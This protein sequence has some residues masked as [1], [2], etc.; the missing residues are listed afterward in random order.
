MVSEIVNTTVSSVN[1]AFCK[2][3]SSLI[4]FGSA[5]SRIEK[6]SAVSPLIPASGPAVK[7]IELGLTG[8]ERAGSDTGSRHG[9]SRHQPNKA[10]AFVQG[11]DGNRR[12]PRHLTPSNGYR[13]QRRSIIYIAPRD[14]QTLSI[15]NSQVKGHMVV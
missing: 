10:Y 15:I 12:R 8:I 5:S 2:E 6:G 4:F 7:S 3:I 14:T 9:V 13:S 1:K 11:G